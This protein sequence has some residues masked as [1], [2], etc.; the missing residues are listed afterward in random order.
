[1]YF[2]FLRGWTM[3]QRTRRL[4]NNGEKRNGRGGTLNLSYC[5]LDVTIWSSGVLFEFRPLFVEKSR[6]T[7]RTKGD[8]DKPFGQSGPTTNGALNWNFWM[9]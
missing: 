7:N 2:Y 3:G 5:A 1:M 6:T 9:E 4:D 8:V